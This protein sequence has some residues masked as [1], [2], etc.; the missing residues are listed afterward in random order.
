ML[1]PLMGYYLWRDR[2]DGREQECVCAFSPSL[3]HERCLAQEQ[4]RSAVNVLA[5]VYE[6]FSE[7][8]DTADL[9][10]AS[11]LLRSLDHKPLRLGQP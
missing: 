2:A 1:A 5:P 6:W 4:R 8:F 3:K 9:I 7:G 10:D 11:A